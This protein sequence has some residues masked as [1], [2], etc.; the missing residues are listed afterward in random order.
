MLFRQAS[1]ATLHS[2]CSKLNRFQEVAFQLWL[3]K[4]RVVNAIYRCVK[5]RY[6]SPRTGYPATYDSFSRSPWA[7]NEKEKPLK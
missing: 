2:E 1:F 5:Y 3:Y 7:K 4:S 6:T